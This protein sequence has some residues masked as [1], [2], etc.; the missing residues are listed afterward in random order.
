MGLLIVVYQPY[1]LAHPR[2]FPEMH[3]ELTRLWMAP[4]TKQAQ[5]LYPLLTTLQG[6]ATKGYTGV[7]APAKPGGKRKGKRP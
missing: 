6:G 2:F 4:F 5:Y 3:E 1:P 7:Q